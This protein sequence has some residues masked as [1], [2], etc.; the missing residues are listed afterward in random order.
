M[1]VDFP[2]CMARLTLRTPKTLVSKTARGA[3]RS[4]LDRADQTA[5]GVVDDDVDAAEPGASTAA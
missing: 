5:P 4:F 1:A 2:I 3:V